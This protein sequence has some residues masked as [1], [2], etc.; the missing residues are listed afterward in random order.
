MGPGGFGPPMNGPP[1]R[2]P[3]PQRNEMLLSSNPDFEIPGMGPRRGGPARG[4]L[5]GPRGGMGMGGSGMVP[6]SAY[7]QAPM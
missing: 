1:R 6:R 3:G 2:A 4:G 5:M 7:D